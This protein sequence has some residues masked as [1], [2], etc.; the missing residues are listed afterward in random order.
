MVWNWQ[1]ADGSFKNKFIVSFIIISG[2][3]SFP[4]GSGCFTHGIFIL[5]FLLL[6]F[7]RSRG[8]VGYASHAH[9]MFNFAKSTYDRPTPIFVKSLPSAS[10]SFDNHYTTV[11]LSFVVLLYFV[12]LFNMHVFIVFDLTGR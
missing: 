11:I 8:N 3:L 4:I 7:S 1:N 5:Q 10:F 9:T 12:S 2:T 6:Y